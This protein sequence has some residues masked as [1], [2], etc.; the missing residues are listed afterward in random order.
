MT[1]AELQSYRRRLL[2]M[3]KRHGGILTDLEVEALRPSGADADGGL[4]E[5]PAHP[6]DLATAEHEEEVTLGLLENEA[7]LLTEIN[8]ALKRIEQ[9]SYGRCAECGQAISRRRL[10]AIPYTTH[11]LG[12]ARTLQGDTRSK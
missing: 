9:G 8:H 2:A 7:H 6:A 1:E 11:C 3:K 10:H 12:C 5:V 4:S